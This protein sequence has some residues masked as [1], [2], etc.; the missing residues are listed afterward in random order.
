L[1]AAA[2]D[3]KAIIRGGIL[4][5]LGL[6]IGSVM[7][8]LAVLGNTSNIKSLEVPLAYI[9]GV[10]SKEVQ[11]IF[12]VILI[13]EVYTTAVGSMFG[14]T[15][16]MIDPEKKPAKE[17]IIILG[18]TIAAFFASLLG[19]SN[20]VKYLYPLVGY[21]GILLLICLAYSKIKSRRSG[22]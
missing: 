19:F 17:K 14:L 15:V 9:A 8:Y 20:L 4:G 10:I 16:R 12:A 21:A 13:A 1:G 6:G 22:I 5:G 18:I 3:K 2:K 7:I 11:M